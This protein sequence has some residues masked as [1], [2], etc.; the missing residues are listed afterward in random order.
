MLSAI[1]IILEAL[2]ENAVISTFAVAAGQ[3]LALTMMTFYLRILAAFLSKRRKYWG[4]MKF[5]KKG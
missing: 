2:V 3:E 5:K 4:W 1:E